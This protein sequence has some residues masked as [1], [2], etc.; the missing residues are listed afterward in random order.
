MEVTTYS[1]EKLSLDFVSGKVNVILG[2]NGV[3]KTTLLD[4]L[5]GVNG[6]QKPNFS[7]VAYKMQNP[8]LFPNI[9]VQEMMAFFASIGNRELETHAGQVIREQF[10]DPLLE[11]RL[12]QLSGGETQLLFDYGTHLLD[13]A[14]YLFDEPT[15]GISFATVPDVL[16]MMEELVESRGKMVITILHELRQIEAVKDAHLIVLNRNKVAF[17]GSREELMSIKHTETFEEAL[18]QLI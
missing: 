3:G 14:A 2:T 5:A 15:A 4:G 1:A 11:R 6:R 13:R 16:T 12:G 17:T 9:T 10:L 7:S 18:M 8:G